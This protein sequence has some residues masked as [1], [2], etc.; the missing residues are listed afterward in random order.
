MSKRELL[1]LAMRRSGMGWMM[2]RLGGWN[3]LLVLN[4]HRVGD[5]QSSPWDKDLFSASE[6]DFD[7]QM[8]FFKSEFDVVGVSDLAGI[9]HR[10]GRFVQVTFDDGYRDNHDLAF[11]ILKAHGLSATFFICTG[12]L[13]QGSVPWWDELA[14]MIRGSSLDRLPGFMGVPELSLQGDARLRAVRVINDV[15]D[16]MSDQARVGFLDAL[17]VVAQTGRCPADQAAQLWM[18]WDMARAMHQG[19]MSIGGHTLS[20]GEL[21]RFSKDEQL[22]E[23]AGSCARIEAEL[24]TPVTTFSYPYGGKHSFNA[25]TRL[26]LDE[27]GIEHA[28]SYNGGYQRTGAWDKH[29]LKRIAVEVSVSEDLLMGM[30]TMP[31]M[32]A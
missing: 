9:E 24:G 11:P 5:W 29:N 23:I 2:R 19:G 31:R 17:G 4:Y 7:A 12:F 3:G 30:A 25:N 14:W 16:E 10:R 20:H 1:A 32:L 27:A 18:T 8:R 22:A 28:Y 26:A 6:E 13:D 15:Y 21:S